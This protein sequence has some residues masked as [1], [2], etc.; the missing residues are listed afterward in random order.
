[1]DKDGFLLVVLEPYCLYHKSLWWAEHN[2]GTHSPICYLAG[3][4][5]GLES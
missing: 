2:S 1:M 4:F 3:M 5:C